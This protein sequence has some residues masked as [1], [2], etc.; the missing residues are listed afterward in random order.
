MADLT[1]AQR[2]RAEARKRRRSKTDADEP[3]ARQ[4]E[5]NGAD[6]QPHDAVKDVAKIAAAG[7]A[8][9][10]AAAAARALTSHND[11]EERGDA[12]EAEDARHRNEQ[13]E[14]VS[15]LDAERDGTQPTTEQREQEEPEPVA[16]E[17][18]E[19]EPVAGAEPDD[20]RAVIDRAREQLEELLERRVE[21][22]SSLERTHNGWVASLEVVELSRIP[23]STDVL[24]S[25]E[26]E[27]DE[28][29]N[30]R[31]YEQVRRY[32]RGRTDRGD[33]A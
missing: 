19:P 2:K 28:D 23:E 11:E 12:P 1:D 18:E 20:A 30:L 13:P 27:L 31:R 5:A 25:Y 9:G 14:E 15:E 21:T 29:L 17:Q 26:M 4:D 24:G 6:E 22:V 8:V 16:R 3:E 7:A 32:H 33:E 10:A